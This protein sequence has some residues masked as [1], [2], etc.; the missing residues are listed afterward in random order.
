MSVRVA[1][2]RLE[3]GEPE[4]GLPEKIAS[5]L[6]LGTGELAGWRILRKSLDARSH[7]DIHFSYSAEVQLADGTRPGVDLEGAA[8][9]Q[10]YLPERFDWPE[11]GGRPLR[12][13]PVIVGSG[14]AGLIAGYLLARDGY[15]PLILE[16]GRAV[17]ERVAD[18]RRFDENGP[19]DPESNYLFG[20][21]GAGTFSDG[22][23]TSRGT[24]PDVRRVLEVLAE[25]HGR[26]S[27]VYEHRPH[28]GSNRLPLVV[29]TLRRKIEEAG[30][31][32]RFSCLV[33]D[34]DIAD[35]RLRGL[36]TSS[37]YIAADL[38]ILAIG[39]SARDTYGVLLRRGVPIAPKPFQLGVRIEQP[40]AS[41]DLARY[42]HYAGHPALGAADYSASVR[43]GR[44]D[45]FTF[46]MCAGG[47]VMP[48]VSD[49]GYFC[50]N[51]MS[52]SRHDSPFANSGL[53]VTIETDE[54]GSDHPLAGI[55]YQQRYERLAY[56]A[57]ER[58]YA[59]APPVG[60]GLPHGAYQPRHHPDE[61]PA[62]R[63][64]DRP[65]ALPAGP[66]RRRPRARPEGPRPPVRRALP[67]RR[68]AHRPRV[69]GQLARPHPPRSG[70]PREPRSRRALPLRRRRRLRGRH[71]QRRRRRPADGACDRWCICE[72]VVGWAVPTGEGLDRR[73]QPTLRGE[74]GVPERRSYSSGW[75]R[76]RSVPSSGSTGIISC[77][78][79][80]RQR[81][82]ST[83]RCSF[84]RSSSSMR[85]ITGRTDSL[86]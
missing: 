48:S 2:I 82:N 32:V 33:E 72:Y 20:E 24:G 11:P 52:E 71:H 13:R 31:E 45:L 8:D 21:G 69:A 15:R 42:G 23:L 1:N 61:L 67:P 40:Q 30:G 4:E 58:S 7:D 43:A 41:I 75:F 39:H 16:R 14:P 55:H 74:A 35:G 70:D 47:Y 63:P 22:K 19:L 44:R 77:L 38:A 36:S 9:V 5:R 66:G 54:F 80:T 53:V 25:C 64:D 83:M 51:G 84:S 62:R 6:G 12:H 37:G 79:T 60:P 26:S 29:R 59:R 49:P 73:A 34:L 18:V 85:W 65:A 86:R 10:P 81:T 46:C 68:D 17:K 76:F 56:L 50:T 3:L 57:G 28:L 27:I 78:R